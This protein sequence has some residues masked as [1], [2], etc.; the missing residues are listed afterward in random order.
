MAREPIP[1]LASVL[2]AQS[3]SGVDPDLV[4]RINGRQW[5]HTIDLGNGL[6]TPGLPPSEVLEGPEAFPA[7]RGRTVLDIGA[8]DGKYSFRAEQAGATRVVAL[9]E[10]V[11]RTDFVK[12]REY[13]DACEATGVV[14]SPSHREFFDSGLTPGKEGFELVKAALDSRVEAVVGD[15]MTMDL[16]M[17]GTFDVVLFLG[18]LYHLVNPLGA[19]E[20]LFQLTREVAVIETE[21]V[22]VPGHPGRM[23]LAF[24]PGGELNGDHTN[25]FAP[26]EAALHAMC[27]SAGFRRVETRVVSPMLKPPLW[28][29]GLNRLS[30]RLAA[31][32]GH[33][34]VVHAFP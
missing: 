25:W 12:R 14:P 6:V 2:A 31:P 23:L 10:Y 28:R 15:F 32:V 17:L 30:R 11:W 9:D 20:R 16:A 33:R 1:N 18:V 34:I 5:F 7:V 19:L 22:L 4:A 21:A 24:Y 13:W 3:I 27:R 29:R 26:T 8:W